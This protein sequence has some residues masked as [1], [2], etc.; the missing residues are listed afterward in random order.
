[1][2]EVNTILQYKG[3]IERGGK[4]VRTL[5]EELRKNTPLRR[6]ASSPTPFLHIITR[7]FYV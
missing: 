1:M 2:D 5:A 7:I 3:K 6:P 4:E